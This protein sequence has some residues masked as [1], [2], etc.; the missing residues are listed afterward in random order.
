[1][2]DLSDK[3]KDFLADWL[4]PT[5]GLFENIITSM[6]GEQA[7]IKK[8]PDIFI[9]GSNDD[10]CGF[11]GI[12]ERLAFY[13]ENKAQIHSLIEEMGY[14]LGFESLQAYI[15]NSL[16]KSKNTEINIVKVLLLNTPDKENKTY[17]AVATWLTY[18]AFE[19]L[20]A[21]YNL[22]ADDTDVPTAICPTF[23]K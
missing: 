20:A 19:G 13:Q 9:T 1:M 12:D 14:F 6:G 17:V 16:D 10:Y 3:M 23:S 21:Y 5:Q 22:F 15:F 7:F 11:S 18:E 4:A 8:Y 2:V